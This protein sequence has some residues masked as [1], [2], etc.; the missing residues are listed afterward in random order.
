MHYYSRSEQPEY[1]NN[2]IKNQLT[3]YMQ[4]DKWDKDNLQEILMEYRVLAVNP[5]STS[6]KIAV[7]DDRRPVFALTLRHDAGKISS[8]SGIIDQYEFR[9]ELVISA[10]A[11]NMIKLDSLNAVVGRGGLVKPVA[12]GTYIINEIMLKD[13][14]NPE[15]WGRI[16]A[17]NLGAFIAKAIADQIGVP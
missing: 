15:I 3:E 9:K 17:S 7:Y 2:Q 5:G 16:H 11:E 10:L 6:T 1:N 4:S 8:F 14:K 13:L 12:S